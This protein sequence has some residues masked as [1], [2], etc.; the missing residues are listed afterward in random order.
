[1]D[2]RKINQYRYEEHMIRGRPY[3]AIN[4]K[5]FYDFVRAKRKSSLSSTEMFYGD[6]FSS[7]YLDISNMFA[8]FFNLLIGSWT[9]AII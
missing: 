8:V 5:S 1:M 6:V 3:L 4:P 9:R 7:S 2:Y